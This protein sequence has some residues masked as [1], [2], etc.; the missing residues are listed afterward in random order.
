MTKATTPASPW[1]KTR[2]QSFREPLSLLLKIFFMKNYCPIFRPWCL[3][4][5]RESSGVDLLGELIRE[6]LVILNH[7]VPFMKVFRSSWHM[8]CHWSKV[9]VISVN[10]KKKCMVYKEINPVFWALEIDILKTFK[11]AI[12]FLKGLVCL[13]GN[14]LIVIQ[15]LVTIWS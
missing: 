5:S 15:L 3:K 14:F 13:M 6:M 7:C 4:S 12:T 1:R 10:I 9:V 11:R 2:A 8:F